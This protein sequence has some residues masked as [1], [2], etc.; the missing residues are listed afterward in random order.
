MIDN[1]RPTELGVRNGV[2]NF[3]SDVVEWF[4]DHI[5]R[6]V[7][8]YRNG[9]ELISLLTDE[10]VKT[11]D[12]V[13]EIGCAT[14]E[15]L[16]TVADMSPRARSASWIGVDNSAK[17]CEAAR[18]TCKHLP[19]VHIIEAAAEDYK[20]EKCSMAI[21][22]LSLQF[23][24]ISE[25][26]KVIEKLYENLEFDGCFFSYVKTYM[27]SAKMQSIAERSLERFKVSRGLTAD[28]ILTKA[29]SISGVLHSVGSDEYIKALHEIGF[30]EV[31]L[32]FGQFGFQGFL[33]LK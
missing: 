9:H 8:L 20:Y 4:P 32:V 30:S 26:C 2:W 28:E 6:S 17:M 13:Y 1:V 12:I 27:R 23:I 19:N 24:S 11:N 22:Y 14:G 10:F 33:G 18:E 3:S 25:R 5:S 7:P 16:A 31:E 21:D 15:L 29:H